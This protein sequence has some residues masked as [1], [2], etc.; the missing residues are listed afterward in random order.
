[1]GDGQTSFQ[2]VQPSLNNA[3]G[4]NNAIA[5]GGLA[6][7]IGSY[8][9][10][11][12]NQIQSG[13]PQSV[14]SPGGGPNALSQMN[15]YLQQYYNAAAL[16]LTQTYQNA[17]MPNIVGNA[18]QTGTV[19]GSG[20]TN[21][22]NLANSGLAQGLGNLAAGIYEPAFAQAQGLSAQEQMQNQALA[23]QSAQQAQQLGAQEL[24]QGRGIGANLFGQG[25]GMTQNAIGMAPS[26]AQG[27]YIPAQEMM[28]S[29]QTAQNQLQQILDSAYNNLFAQS[30]WP[31]QQLGVLGQGLGTVGSL[32]QGTTTQIQPSQGG[33]K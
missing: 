20:Q 17:T 30:Q 10:N 21:A 5:Q 15:P 31:Q 7:P 22:T 13:M 28:Q 12:M 29:G 16:P 11:L 2:G 32:G 26:L 3:I 4:M 33:F 14:G 9:T 19:G 1:M 18:A 25:L 6:G 24:M 8:N 27:A 23:T